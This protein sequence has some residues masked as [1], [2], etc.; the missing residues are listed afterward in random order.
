MSDE[1]DLKYLD[2]EFRQMIA[3][4]GKKFVTWNMFAE[5]L[6]L[7]KAMNLKNVERNARLDALEQRISALEARPS[8]Q[9]KGVWQCGAFYEPGDI[10]S[11]GGSAWIRRGQSCGRRRRFL[12]HEHFRLLVKRGRDAR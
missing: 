10:V 4:H 7:A 9:D 8:I 12:S 5:A 6:N 3:K 1:L 2:D 11:R